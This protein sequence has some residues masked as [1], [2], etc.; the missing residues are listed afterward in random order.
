MPVTPKPPRSL[1]EA[2]ERA[3]L[4][5]HA[6]RLREMK[7]MEGQVALLDAFVPALA[8]RG[9]DMIVVAKHLEW[10]STRKSLRLSTATLS[11]TFE[12][13]LREALL[14][15]G[16]TEV[17]RDEYGHF[18]CVILAKACRTL[19]GG[20]VSLRLTFHVNTPRQNAAAAPAG[21][22]A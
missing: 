4:Q 14:A 12:K 13:G 3:E 11:G 19:A 16:F 22:A 1:A 20:S 10:D 2:I 17:Q 5:R 6:A 7:T 9:V 21:G 8:E 18:A 15:I